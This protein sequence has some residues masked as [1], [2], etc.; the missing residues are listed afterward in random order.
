MSHQDNLKNDKTFINMCITI[1]Y[2][3]ALY[4]LLIFLVLMLASLLSDLLCDEFGPDTCIISVYP[5]LFSKWPF[6]MCVSSFMSDTFIRKKITIIVIF[7]KKNTGHELLSKIHFN[8]W[9]YGDV[10][11][12]IMTVSVCGPG[13]WLVYELVT[14]SSNALWRHTYKTFLQTTIIDV[15]RML[16]Y[17]V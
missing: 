15:Q 10:Y 2:E 14:T 8:S 9:S 17:H 1:T 11:S 16:V 5:S 7:K 3:K 13:W 4:V 6:F 12:I